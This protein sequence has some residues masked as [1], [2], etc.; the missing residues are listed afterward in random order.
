MTKYRPAMKL[1]LRD[2]ESL[3]KI[4]QNAARHGLSINEYILLAIEFAEA[5]M[6]KRT[7]DVQKEEQ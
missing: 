1:R 4:K 2:E 6:A 3:N 5:E 7:S